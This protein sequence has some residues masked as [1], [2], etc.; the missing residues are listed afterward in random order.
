MIQEHLETI[1]HRYARARV[2]EFFGKEHELWTV[3]EAAAGELS[4]QAA[5]ARRP[6]LKVTWSAGQGGWAKVPWIALLDD[7]ETTTTQRGV[8]CVYLFRQDMSGSRWGTI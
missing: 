5:V 2:G 8:Y 3:F 1:L 6:H 4:T 7:R